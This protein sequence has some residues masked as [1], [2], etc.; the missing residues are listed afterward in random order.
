M[1][2][3]DFEKLHAQYRPRLFGKMRVLLR[4]ADD[5]E[6]VTATV[7]LRAFKH[8]H[9]FRGDAC[10]YT[11][12]Y[13]IAIN[14]LARRRIKPMVSLD[15]MP[16]GDRDTP[17][18]QDRLTQNLEQRECGARVRQ[19]LRRI[20]AIYRRALADHFLRGYSVKQIARQEA[21]AV[22][23]VGSRIFTAKRYLRAAWDIG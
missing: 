17:C 13:R 7:F 20:P 23:T 8:R 5:A 22:G 9:Q 15:A 6:D 21:V 19:A 14:H 10:F 18:E 3:V 16:E 11:W 12:L 2:A 1:N 4:N